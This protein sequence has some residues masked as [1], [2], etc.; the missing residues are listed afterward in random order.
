MVEEATLS[1]RLDALPATIRAAL[2]GEIDRLARALRKRAER[3]APGER[4]SLAV[5]NSSDAVTATLTARS[6]DATRPSAAMKPKPGRAL[7]AAR[8]ER[9]HGLPRAGNAQ[10]EPAGLDAALAATAPAIR[11]G[12]EM[13]VRQ[14]L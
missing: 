14:A 12:L 5:D 13:A 9:P 4:V 11:A 3:Q 6:A 1:A 7:A 10:S 8:R 2:A